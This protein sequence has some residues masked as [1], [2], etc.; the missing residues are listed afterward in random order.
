MK[1][2]TVVAIGGDSAETIVSDKPP[3]QVANSPLARSQFDT[4]LSVGLFAVVVTLLMV[5]IAL[6]SLNIY[7]QGQN[8]SSG[9]RRALEESG[10]ARVNHTVILTYSRAADFAITKTS[11]LFLAFALVLTGALYVL[12]TATDRFALSVEGHA[13]K[14]SLET[15]SPG[16][17][18]ITLGVVLVVFVLSSR[19]PVEYTPPPASDPTGALKSGETR[20]PVDVAPQALPPKADK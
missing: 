9:I 20:T 7:F 4:Y 8:Y 6:L 18:M 1:S 11:A 15:S 14:G 13:T 10:S 19:S 5:V 3:S 17:V 16:L 12:R 2:P